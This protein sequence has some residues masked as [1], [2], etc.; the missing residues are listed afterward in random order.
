MLIRVI[1]ILITITVPV[2]VRAFNEK[3]YNKILLLPEGV[4]DFCT[5]RIA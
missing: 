1:V 3:I 2:K 4:K 5:D